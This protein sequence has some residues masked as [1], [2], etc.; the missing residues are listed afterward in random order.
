MAATQQEEA[1]HARQPIR[2]EDEG[3]KAERNNNHGASGNDDHII[4]DCHKID[5]GLGDVSGI[6]F[7]S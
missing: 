6:F 1:R 5:D 4:V 3:K 2:D 7:S